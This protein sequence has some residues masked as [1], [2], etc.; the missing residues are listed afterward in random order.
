MKKINLFLAGIFALGSLAAQPVADNAVIPVAVTLNSI[1]RMNV[2]SGGNIEFIVNT[3]EQYQNGII[4]SDRYTTKFTVAS[5]VDFNVE[6]YAEDATFIGADDATNT[7]PLN[8]VGYMMGISGTGTAGT[9]WVVAGGASD[10]T[11]LNNTATTAI[12]E[13]IAGLGAGD[14]T[15][16]AFEIKWELGT[17]S[18]NLI[19]QSL[20]QQ[21]LPAD[22]YS[23]NVFLVL[24]AI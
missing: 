12:V 23:T 22:R 18:G 17:Q 16:N 11:A 3:M 14:V 7:M 13:S 24:S 19:G 10:V 9:N 21:S 8:N 15:Q 20:M 1:L 4:N 5:S 6:M 2:T